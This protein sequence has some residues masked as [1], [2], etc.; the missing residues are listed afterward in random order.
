MDLEM[1]KW[2]TDGKRSAA[3]LLWELDT[4]ID[5]E[6]WSGPSWREP[7]DIKPKA[8]SSMVILFGRDDDAFG[9]MTRTAHLCT[10]M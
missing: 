10:H 2:E 5:V 6:R 3:D 1:E 8:A 4:S 9:L 7:E